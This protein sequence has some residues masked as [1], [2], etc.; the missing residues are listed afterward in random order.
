M[1]GEADRYPFEK[2]LKSLYGLRVTSVSYGDLLLYAD[3]L[4]GAKE[5]RALP[6]LRLVE[7]ALEGEM[8]PWALKASLTIGAAAAVAARA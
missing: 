8:A 2:E 4:P 7:R 6:L 1:F 5:S 3:F